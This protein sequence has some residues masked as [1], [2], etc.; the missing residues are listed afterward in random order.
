ML[1]DLAWIDSGERF[2]VIAGNQ[3]AVAT[4]YD[5][6]CNALFEFGKRYRNTIRFCPFS[7]LL[8]I[9]GFGN[10]KGEID[11]WNLDSL[12][13]VGKARSDC[14]IDIE[15]APDGKHLMTSVIYARVK[16]DNQISIFN[17][18]GKRVTNPPKAFEELNYVQW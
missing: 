9:G 16:V 12:E 3:P 8:L 5:K 2:I 10:L 13:Q 6:D 4:L 1:N 17:G 15:Y 14:A 7:Q 11:V 18:C